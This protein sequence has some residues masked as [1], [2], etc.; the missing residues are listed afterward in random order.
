M[1]KPDLFE[2]RASLSVAAKQTTKDDFELDKNSTG[3]SSSQAGPA[4]HII[5]TPPSSPLVLTTPRGGASSVLSLQQQQQHQQQQQPYVSSAPI[6]RALEAPHKP[7]DLVSSKCS[8][9][10]PTVNPTTDLEASVGTLKTAK[11]QHFAPELLYKIFSYLSFTQ[12]TLGTCALVCKQWNTIACTILWRR[13]IFTSLQSPL[14]LTGSSAA[15]STNAGGGEVEV[16]SFKSNDQHGDGSGNH[17]NFVAQRYASLVRIIDFT[18]LDE[19][20][21]NSTVLSQHIVRL[22]PLVQ[23]SLQ[24]LD[25]GFN[26]GVKN[27]DLQRLSPW[28]SNLTSLNLAGGSRTDIVLTKLSK[29]CPNLTR[30]SVSWNSQLTDFGFVEM[31]R[32]CRKLRALDVTNCAQ[33]TD[34]GVMAL[35]V[36]CTQLRVLSVSY[37]QCVGE[38][39][40]W[41]LVRS[42]KELKLINALGCINLS[43]RFPD[44]LKLKYPE[45]LINVPGVL[46]FYYPEIA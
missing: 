20:H 7:C 25:L 14:L 28:L 9:F 45:L 42:C 17:S 15:T 10:S 32:H 40:I 24:C 33:I 38:V 19:I 3:E 35:A 5:P 26:K 34:T 16:G 11:H 30:L 44:E 37:C 36:Y 31:A 21:R 43:R 4:K 6:S 1:T 39:A 2:R 41:E 27:F 22:I 18:L 8:T 12:S 46:P 13:P 23:P 29:H